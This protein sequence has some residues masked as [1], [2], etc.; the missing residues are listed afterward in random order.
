MTSNITCRR[1]SM[2]A[3]ICVFAWYLGLF[4]LLARSDET[5]PSVF[6]LP[7][8]QKKYLTLKQQVEDHL[9]QGAYTQAEALSQDAIRLI[10]QLPDA[11]YWKACALAGQG[12]LDA[13]LQS[14]NQ[15][16][17][18]GYR[19]VDQ[20]KQDERLASLRSHTGYEALLERASHAKENP[21]LRYEANPKTVE[22]GVAWVD[23]DNTVW[24]VRRG[25]FL[26][27][28]NIPTSSKDSTTEPVLGHGEVGDLIRRWYRE[29]TAAGNRGD[30]YDNHDNDHSNLR[31]QDFPQLTRIEYSDAAKKYQLHVGLQTQFFYNGLIIGNSSMAHT[32]APT[33]RSLPRIAYTDPRRAALLY[34][35]YTNNHLYVYPE[36]RDHDP[37]HNG[38]G[39]YGDVYCANTP[40]VLI[41]QGSSGSDRPFLDALMCT[42]AAF[43]PEV[44][45]RL[46][47]RRLVAPTLQM[48]FRRCYGPVESDEDYLTG[49]AHP[50]VFDGKQLEPKRMVEFA[51]QVRSD[52]IPPMVQIRV[53][54][55]DQFE[56]GQDYFDIA[57]RENLFDTPAAICR[58]HRARQ[59]KR[60]M[61]ISAEG[62]FDVNDRPLS[63]HWAVLRGDESSIVIRPLNDKRSVAELVIPYHHR[64]PIAPGAAIESNRVDIGV[65]V[66]NGKYYSAPAFVSVHYLDNEQRV[67]GEDGRILSITYEDPTADGNY[68]DPVLATACQWRDE[69]QYDDQGHLVGWTR[70]YG[71]L[72]QEFTRDGALV[73]R[74]DHL[75][76][77]VTGRSVIYD[78]AIRPES[79]P[80][81]EPRVGDEILY[82]EYAS[83]DDPV[84]RVSKREPVLV[85]PRPASGD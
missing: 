3:L 59:F 40:Y 20:L 52:E 85:T 9:N 54:E 13:A 16:V 2:A 74:R 34:A 71:P 17:D 65:F 6:A 79:I 8:L 18:R 29:G 51:H 63:Y 4:A 36:H 78:V 56:V 67:Y 45:R 48:I 1:A 42:L 83:D 35:Q 30:F 25:L 12:Q 69:Y 70:L 76:R 44:K 82:Y 61:V 23:E 64:R 46:R 27:L 10:A 37:G 81:L 53:V 33:W 41:S 55:E 68:I 73:L 80:L 43:R 15:A 47:E 38:D 50:T 77:P 28:F 49:K 72:R 7:E 32:G 60:R 57:P 39:G 26:V 84:G 75:N 58:I 5:R 14:L 19:N 11:H 22:N 31:Y 24:D 62:S 21:A 66:H